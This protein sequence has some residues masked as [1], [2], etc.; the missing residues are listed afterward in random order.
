M[1]WHKLVVHDIYFNSYGMTACHGICSVIQEWNKEQ[2][3]VNVPYANN[4]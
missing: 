2:T 1:T 4:I 3:N